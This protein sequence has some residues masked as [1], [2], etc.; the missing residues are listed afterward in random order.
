M[1]D[2]EKSKGKLRLLLQVLGGLL[3]LGSLVLIFAPTLVS[4]PGPSPDL[5]E[6]IERRV[7][8]GALTGLGG[9]MVVLYPW[10]PWPVA[11]LKFAFWMSTGYLVARV[12]GIGMEGVGSGKQWLWLGVELVLMVVLI[13]IQRK[14]FP[15]HSLFQIS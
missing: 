6:T 3:F 15:E 5:F 2:S 10:K 7:R 9:F 8:W 1:P 11:L 13:A 12:I 14:K 4:N